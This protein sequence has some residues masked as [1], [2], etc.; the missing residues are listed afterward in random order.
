VDSIKSGFPWLYVEKIPDD[1]TWLSPSPSDWIINGRA[2]FSLPSQTDCELHAAVLA[3]DGQA[4]YRHDH[5]FAHA[6]GKLWG[7]KQICE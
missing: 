1:Q 4:K 5:A 2:A 3:V 6:D 7:G